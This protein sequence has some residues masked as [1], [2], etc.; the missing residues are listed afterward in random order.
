ML[1]AKAGPSNSKKSEL[2]MYLWWFLVVVPCLAAS[3]QFNAERRLRAGSLLARAPVNSNTAFR[4][5]RLPA[6]ASPT[7]LSWYSDYSLDLRTMGTSEYS[8]S[9]LSDILI[10]FSSICITAY[11][12][13]RAWK[14]WW[15]FIV[16]LHCIEI[17]RIYIRYDDMADYLHYIQ[18]QFGIEP[19]EGSWRSKERH[20]FRIKDLD[21]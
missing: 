17:Q 11:H 2:K 16:Y 19:S 13:Y 1:K 21:S 3:R 8:H 20:I 4:Q 10:Q 12:F 14:R 6:T 9:V 7:R 18:L 15:L 5:G